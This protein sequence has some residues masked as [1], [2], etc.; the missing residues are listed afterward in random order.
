MEGLLRL[1]QRRLSLSDQDIG[2][3]TK[4]LALL[5]EL[6]RRFSDLL[7]PASHFRG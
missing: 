5:H 6:L 1:E 4:L 2:S 7:R 3:V